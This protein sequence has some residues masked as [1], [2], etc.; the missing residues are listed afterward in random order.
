MAD[1]WIIVAIVKSGTP[2]TGL[3]P[4]IRITDIDT[5]VLVI[6]DQPMTDKGDGLYGYLFT[7]YDSTK[8][9]GGR[10]DA[11]A[12]L[13]PERDQFFGNESFIP[14]LATETKATLNKNEILD[15]VDTLSA[16]RPVAK[17]AK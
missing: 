5:D 3:T 14:E 16:V 12:T 8:N 1:K 13:G 10:V 11:G 2:Q 4:T 17:F 6:T 15:A 7:T 9:Y